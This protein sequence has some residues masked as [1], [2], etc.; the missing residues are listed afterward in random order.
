MLRNANPKSM[1]SWANLLLEY[2]PWL[3]GAPEGEMVDL[4]GHNSAYNRD[5]LLS[6]G[7]RLESLLEVEAVVQREIIQSGHRML[8]EPR[9]RTSHLN[10]SRLTSSLEL[11]F[12]AG[13]SFAGH[14]AM[15]WPAKKRAM[16]IAGGPLI[17]LVR[18]I[19]ISTMLRRSP[20][21]SWLFP[22]VIP[23]LCAMLLADGFGETAGYVAGPGD[24]PR[25]LGTIEFN[26]VRFM[27]L[28]DKADYAEMIGRLA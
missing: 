15:G 26:R 7:D 5:L 10:F 21:Y 2:Y 4:P 25:F 13:R 23:A 3:E 12:N 8:L 20:Q 6:F 14:R 28:S 9:A 22:K 17:P 24:A 27:N 16:Y 18:L 1:T 19:R 11:R